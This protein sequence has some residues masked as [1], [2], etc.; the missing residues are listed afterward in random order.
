MVITFI[1]AWKDMLEM[2]SGAVQS[3][4]EHRPQSTSNMK[5]KDQIIPPRMT[6]DTAKLLVERL[7][8]LKV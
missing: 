2:A 7:Y 8:G 3:S 4:S 1:E 5:E 6:E